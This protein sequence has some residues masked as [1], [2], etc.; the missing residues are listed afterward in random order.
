MRGKAAKTGKKRKAAATRGVG[1]EGS[2]RGKREGLAFEG[3]R[4]VG[5]GERDWEK[6]VGRGRLDESGLALTMIGRSLSL[7]V[8]GPSHGRERSE[9]PP[10]LPV[11]IASFTI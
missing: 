6:E 8:S 9:G 11:P 7:E 4:S 1:R 3:K 2:A 5:E 10:A